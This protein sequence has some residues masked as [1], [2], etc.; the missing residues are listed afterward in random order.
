MPTRAED[1]CIFLQEVYC[2][3]SPV[4]W[5]ALPLTGAAPPLSALCTAKN[6]PKGQPSDKMN[7]SEKTA[8]KG[9]VMSVGESKSSNQMLIPETGSDGAASKL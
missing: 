5:E 6:A 7:K 4:L 2:P 3:S 9:L 8:L 1:L